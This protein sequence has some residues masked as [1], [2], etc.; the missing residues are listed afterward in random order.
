LE[1]KFINIV[2]RNKSVKFAVALLISM[3]L[4]GCIAE[5]VTISKIRS[6]PGEFVGKKVIIS[7]IYMGWQSNE[8]PPV[9]RSDWV[10]ADG[11]GSIHVTGLTPNLDPLGDIGK[12][13]TVV[14]YVRLGERPYLEAVKLKV[15]G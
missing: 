8:P 7:G 6:N 12:N 5:K 11:T 4:I 2:F 15:L 10:I 14:G 13:L 9:T 1:E 3:I